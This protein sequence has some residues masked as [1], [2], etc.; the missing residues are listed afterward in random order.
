MR[1]KGIFVG[2]IEKT[3]HFRGGEELYIMFRNFWDGEFLNRKRWYI[4]K[5]KELEETPDRYDSIALCG[6]SKWFAVTICSSV[7]IFSISSNRRDG[8]I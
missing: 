2:L 3:F 7:E 1:F 5:G 6:K 4:A 8:D